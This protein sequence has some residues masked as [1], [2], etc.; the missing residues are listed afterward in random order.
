MEIRVLHE[1]RRPNARIS[2]LSL[3]K[4]N[5]SIHLIGKCCVLHESWRTDA[6]VRSLAPPCQWFLYSAMYILRTRLLDNPNVSLYY[7]GT[8]REE[9]VPFALNTIVGFEPIDAMKFDDE[10]KAI[11]LCEK[12]NLN[13]Q[14]LIM[15]G[16]SEFEAIIKLN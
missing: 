2:R 8:A 16:Y 9:G 1:I 10:Q 11:A 14:E 15:V 4:A 6:P 7:K 12:L 3:R 13:K 5:P